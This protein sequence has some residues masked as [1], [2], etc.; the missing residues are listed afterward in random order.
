MEMPTLVVDP[1]VI[2]SRRPEVAAREDRDMS[3]WLGWGSK[4]EGCPSSPPRCA[5]R[6]SAVEIA[7]PRHLGRSLAGPWKSMA[8][9]SQRCSL[10]PSDFF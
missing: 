5:M 9:H 7:A 4:P 1:V 3:C 8:L 6:C 2:A 10:F